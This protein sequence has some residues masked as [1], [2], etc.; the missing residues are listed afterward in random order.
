MFIDTLWLLRE[1]LPLNS[2]RFYRQISLYKQPGNTSCQ[3]ST[4]QFS[5]CSGNYLNRLL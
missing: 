4:A 3:A 2:W 1:D 5:C